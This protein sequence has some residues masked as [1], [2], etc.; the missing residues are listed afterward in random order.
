[1]WHHAEHVEIF[2]INSGNVVGGSIWIGSAAD[3]ALGVAIAKG[4]ETIAFEP[5]YG[6]FMR[7]VIAFAVG[8]GDIDRLMKSISPRK[9]GVVALDAQMLAFSNETQIAVT[10]ENAR[11]QAAFA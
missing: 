3:L 10:H 1:M 2:R 11:Q 8:D 7:F 9:G 6:L 5:L 4:H